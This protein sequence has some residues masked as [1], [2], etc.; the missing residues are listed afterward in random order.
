MSGPA[1]RRLSTAARS[2]AALAHSTWFRVADQGMVSSRFS[3][4]DPLHEPG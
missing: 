3:A 1:L 2:H 4:I